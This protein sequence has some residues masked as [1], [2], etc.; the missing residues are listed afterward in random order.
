MGSSPVSSL[1][2]ELFFL[3]GATQVTFC[4]LSTGKKSKALFPIKGNPKAKDEKYD[5]EKKQGPLSNPE[6]GNRNILKGG[7]LEKG[8]VLA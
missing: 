5:R 7:I 8:E 1:G 6:W 3:K 2:W 4:F